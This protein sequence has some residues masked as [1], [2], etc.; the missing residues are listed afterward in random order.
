MFAPNVPRP[1]WQFLAELHYV[2]NTARDRGIWRQ[3]CP[4][5]V[6][7]YELPERK[8]NLD[9][10]IAPRDRCSLSE[11]QSTPCRPATQP[12][13]GTVA[14]DLAAFHNRLRFRRY[15][16]A[17]SQHS[18]GSRSAPWVTEPDAQRKPRRGFTEAGS[19]PRVPFI[20]LQSIF[21]AHSPEL[22]LECLVTMMRLLRCDVALEGVNVTRTD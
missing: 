12:M 9:R 5:A 4:T 10:M 22:I 11:N 19:I 8:A 1:V 3:Y 20:Y 17:V 2:V 16:E 7:A 14:S 13:A 18:P 15:R 21:P 6:V